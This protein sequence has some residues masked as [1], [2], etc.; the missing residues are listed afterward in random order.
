MKEF[1][2]NHFT[3]DT[4]L[5]VDKT[6]S[7]VIS[8]NEKFS[9]LVPSIF[10]MICLIDSS[11]EEIHNLVERILSTSINFESFS[12]LIS[13]SPFIYIEQINEIFSFDIAEIKIIYTTYQNFDINENIKIKDLIKFIP[14]FEIKINNWYSI[15]YTMEST[16]KYQLMN[17]Q[18]FNISNLCDIIK[19]ISIENGFNNFKSFCYGTLSE[20]IGNFF[21]K[22]RK[23]DPQ[24][25]LVLIDRSKFPSL[26]FMEPDS[27]IDHSFLLNPFLTLNDKEYINLDISTNTEILLKKIAEDIKFIQNDI[28]FEKLNLEWNKLN[29]FQIK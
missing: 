8:L 21:E 26:L 23:N 13:Q 1:L 12:I 27:L 5:F 29:K 25:A 18:Y 2:I 24:C 9:N 28:T 22:E 19:N 16:L 15:I 14:N 4:I 6:I 17:D 11:I 3:K 20:Q 10:P 7:E